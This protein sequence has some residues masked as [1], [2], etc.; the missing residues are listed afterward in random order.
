MLSY[1]ISGV[2]SELIGRLKSGRNIS[3]LMSVVLSL[4]LGRGENGSFAHLH[5]SGKRTLFNFIRKAKR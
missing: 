5:R 2:R 3:S 4:E 1:V